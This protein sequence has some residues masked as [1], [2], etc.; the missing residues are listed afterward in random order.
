M[1][2]VM[3]SSEVFTWFLVGVAVLGVAYLLWKLWS[4]RQAD[5]RYAQLKAGAGTDVQE[6]L[7]GKSFTIGTPSDFNEAGLVGHF[8]WL[9]GERAWGIRLGNPKSSLRSL[10][11]T[12][13]PCGSC[14]ARRRPGFVTRTEACG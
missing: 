12:P 9:S 5:S 14:K 3:T 4:D 13:F 8:G 2:Q 6:A 7:Q 1:S 10:E 11:G